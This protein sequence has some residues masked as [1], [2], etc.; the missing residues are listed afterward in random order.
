MGKHAKNKIN[1]RSISNLLLSERGI[2]NCGL[3]K[4][5]KGMFKYMRDNN[6]LDYRVSIT[7]SGAI[8]GT[9]LYLLTYS[10]EQSPSWEAKTS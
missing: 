5:L 1:F 2:F 9:S 7:T 8:Q 6:A 3:H 10:M 4:T